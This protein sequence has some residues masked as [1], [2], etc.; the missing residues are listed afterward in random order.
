LLGRGASERSVFSEYRS[1]RAEGAKPVINNDTDN[2]RTVS[3][4]LK[5]QN[6]FLGVDSLYLVIEY[7][8]ADIYEYWA[9][10]VTSLADA[11]LYQGVPHGNMLV[12]R[13]ALGY[14]LSV[15]SGD[16]RLF[17]T[18]RVNDKL[19]DSYEAGQG[20]GLMLQL[21]TKWLQTHA[22]FTS[23][24][25]L[26]APIFALLREFK[27]EKPENYPLRINRLDVALDVAGLA[28]A[29]FSVDEWREGWVGRASGKHF[30]DDNKTGKLSGLAIGSSEGAVRFKVYDK[31]LEASKTHDLYFWLSVW[32][33]N[34]LDYASLD[35]A[36]VARFEWS[37]KPHEAKFVNMRYLSDYTFDKLKE[38]LNYVTLSW[39][40]L[41]LPEND[42]NQ[43]RRQAHPLWVKIR[44]MMIEEWNIDHVGRAK[45]DYHTAPD[46][47]AAYMNSVTG[48][49]GGLM[50]RLGLA[51]GYNRPADLVEA[52][53]L[54]ERESKPIV[55]KAI[56]KWEVLSRL[57]GNNKN[58]E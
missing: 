29:D 6:V 54:A 37:F 13:G 30:Y 12:R 1:A 53:R 45:R 42:S 4:G 21:G 2:P 34:G 52:L 5:L 23:Y 8:H 47:N 11:R 49:L 33:E 46:L 48:W 16:S 31:F 41:C 28:V 20:M 43:S 25:A 24:D 22:D 17:I 32:L 38:L 58:G 3:R 56:E 36:A 10:A 44:R 27:L 9:A 7:P 35:G 26:A 57:H 19:I 14:K 51:N 39:G 15:W 55:Q 50:A 18:D 40:R